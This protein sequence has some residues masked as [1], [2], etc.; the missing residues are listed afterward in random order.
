M[1]FWMGIRASFSVFYSYLVE[2]FSWGRGEAAIAQSIG[3]VMY[4]VSVP[5]IGG[6]IDRLGPRKVVIPGILLCTVGLF[7]C[8]FTDNLWSFYLFYG[9]LV[10]TGV[11]FFSIVTYSS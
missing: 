6:L 3:F 11:S 9:V 8:S 10:G 1:A 7:L 2:E 5:F 4:M